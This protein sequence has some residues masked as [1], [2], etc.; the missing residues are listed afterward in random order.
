MNDSFSASVKQ[1]MV[2]KVRLLQLPTEWVNRWFYM[3]GRSFL[4]VIC[5]QALLYSDYRN[6]WLTTYP[7]QVVISP[8]LHAFSL[9]HQSSSHR[10]SF[11]PT[12]SSKT[13]WP[14]ASCS[15][16]LLIG[17]EKS[18]VSVWWAVCWWEVVGPCTW[19]SGRRA[20][21]C[22]RVGFAWTIFN[23]NSYI[24]YV[25]SRCIIE[26]QLGSLSSQCSDTLKRK[27]LDD[28]ASLFSFLL[29][30]CFPQPFPWL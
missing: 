8:I 2:N 25:F 21:D 23:K 17:V 12:I 16:R 27:V 26:L 7:I 24:I 30:Q 13:A 29:H 22:K 1:Q 6:A 5:L 20:C 9:F 14:C 11:L 19:W 10:H 3:R 4:L 15:S 18:S 28:F